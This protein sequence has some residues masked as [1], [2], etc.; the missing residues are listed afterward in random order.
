MMTFIS[1]WRR[2]MRSSQDVRNG[3]PKFFKGIIYLLFGS[4]KKEV[5]DR[6]WNEAFKARSY[7]FPEMNEAKSTGSFGSHIRKAMKGTCIQRDFQHEM[8]VFEVT[9]CSLQRTRSSSLFFESFFRGLVLFLKNDDHC[10]SDTQ[11][12]TPKTKW[13]PN[14]LNLREKG[15]RFILSTLKTP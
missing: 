13:L 6:S 15:K 3:T 10:L 4:S 11:L 1:R 8:K 14:W 12:M 5:D 2:D 7:S 9:S